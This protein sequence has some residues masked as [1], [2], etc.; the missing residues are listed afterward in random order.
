MRLTRFTDLSLRVLMYLAYVDRRRL[1]TVSELAE[2]IDWTQNHVTKVVHR[3]GQEGWIT[4][5]RGR[6]GGVALEKAPSEY[7]LGD[8]IRRLEDETIFDCSDPACHLDGCQLTNYYAQA[9]EAFYEELNTITLA[10]AVQNAQ[11][12][13]SY[14]RID[15]R[16]QSHELRPVPKPVVP[17]INLIRRKR[18]TDDTTR[19]ASESS[20]KS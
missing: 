12:R 18:H 14:A 8:L 15:R 4:T 11:I 17:V 3:L 9:L 10:D 20:Q 7:H 1:V 5:V 2:K 19:A 13:A 6:M 16:Y